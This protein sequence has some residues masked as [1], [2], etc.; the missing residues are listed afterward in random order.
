MNF[1]SLIFSR[2]TI[3]PFVSGVIDRSRSFTASTHVLRAPA[4]A[5]C[6][7]RGV[8]AT[9]LCSARGVQLLVVPVRYFALNFF[10]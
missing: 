2:V 8:P 6:S 3:F 9:A 1:L 5:L 4:T 10:Q 7:A